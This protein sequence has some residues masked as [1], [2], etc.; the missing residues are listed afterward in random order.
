MVV[1]SM[2]VSNRN[3]GQN[4]WSYLHQV[5]LLGRRRGPATPFRVMP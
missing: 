1:Q 4:N 2:G 3:G 5:E